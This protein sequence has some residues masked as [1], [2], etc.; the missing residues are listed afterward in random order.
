MLSTFLSTQTTLL[1]EELLKGS[2]ENLHLDLYLKSD[3]RKRRFST[4]LWQPNA[5]LLTQLAHQVF[6]QS[7]E[8]NHLVGGKSRDF[9]ELESTVAKSDGLQQLVSE[10]TRSCG[11]TREAVEVGVHQIRISCSP[12]A[13]GQP[14]PEGVHQ[15]G[16]EFIG[17]YCVA[18]ENVKGGVTMLYRSKG[19]KPFFQTTLNPGELLVFNDEQLFHFTSPIKSLTEEGGH[20]DVF[21]LTGKGTNSSH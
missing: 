21:I 3:S 18:R 15:D 4:F 9:A 1:Q 12:N 7:Q 8:Y 2:F 19:S 16:F 13:W 11:L 14:A 6:S 17:I 20:R 5:K 10:F